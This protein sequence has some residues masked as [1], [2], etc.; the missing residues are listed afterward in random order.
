MV[1][2]VT[3]VWCTTAGAGSFLLF[4]SRLNTSV[5]AGI[6]ILAGL[7]EL[8]HLLGI[9]LIG[10][11]RRDGSEVPKQASTSLSSLTGNMKP[12]LMGFKTCF[13]W[14]CNC[15]MM[16]ERCHSLEKG[17]LVSDRVHVLDMLGDNLPLVMKRFQEADA[18]KHLRSPPL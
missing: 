2:R 1:H 6:R 13:V 18:S 10:T 12:P 14:S 15:R 16:L 3:F 11:L 7:D 9:L 4:L 8:S 5:L 17:N